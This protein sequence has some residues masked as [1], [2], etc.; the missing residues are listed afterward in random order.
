M[1]WTR[2]GPRLLWRISL[3]LMACYFLLFNSP[4]GGFAQ[5]KR[6]AEKAGSS[7]GPAEAPK[8]VAV[9]P[10][11]LAKEASL[12]PGKIQSAIASGNYEL[13]IQEERD[14]EL[15]VAASDSRLDF[16]WRKRSLF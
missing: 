5:D 7:T 4:I 2:W 12:A 3:R 15:I 16:S 1:P 14:K 6:T 13:F 8:K 11:E 9:D 10:L